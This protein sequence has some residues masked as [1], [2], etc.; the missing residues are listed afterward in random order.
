MPRAPCSSS[1][2]CSSHCSEEMSADANAAPDRGRQGRGRTARSA[3]APPVDQAKHAAT[4]LRPRRP[5]RG[6]GGDRHVAR[7]PGGPSLARLDSITG[8]PPPRSRARARSRRAARPRSADINP[9]GSQLPLSGCQ[10]KVRAAGHSR[11]DGQG[12]RR[13]VAAAQWQPSGP[14][15]CSHRR[16]LVYTRYTSL[17]APCAAGKGPVSRPSVGATPI[18]PVTTIDQRPG[19]GVVLALPPRTVC[20]SPRDSARCCA[21]RRSR[22]TPRLGEAAGRLAARLALAKARA[23]VRDA[24]RNALLIGSD[25]VPLT[26]QWLE[27]PAMPIECGCACSQ[28]AAES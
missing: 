27:N 23:L 28:R 9:G 3:R 25:Q 20:A 13:R 1:R 7:S 8:E 11:L 21:P 16:S 4:A 18:D 19:S 24:K 26:A 6:P 10:D 17:A 12:A 2:P 15:P 22:E 5:R 14:G